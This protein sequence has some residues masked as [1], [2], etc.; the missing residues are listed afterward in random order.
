VLVGL[1][2]VEL[3]GVDEVDGESL[4]V[5]IEQRLDRPSCPKC[6]GSPMVKDRH[7]VVLVDLRCFS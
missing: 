4:L 7:D 1:P 2:D 6:G 3:L 5:H